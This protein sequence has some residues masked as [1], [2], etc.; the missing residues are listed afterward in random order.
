MLQSKLVRNIHLSLHRIQVRY[1]SLS[2]YQSIRPLLTKQRSWRPSPRCW[3][4]QSSIKLLSEF[5]VCPLLVF[6]TKDWPV[7]W[8]FLNLNKVS[9]FY[10]CL[11][12]FL[13]L[14][15]HYLSLLEKEES[16][17]ENVQ[18][19]GLL[20]DSACSGEGYFWTGYCCS[21]DFCLT[22]KIIR[23]MQKYS[24]VAGR[25]SPRQ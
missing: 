11:F 18:E 23:K 10:L 21:K 20:S 12:Y 5:F 17:E 7:V 9:C 22:K 3:G 8:Y 24:I 4:V 25:K 16:K 14:K 1:L 6:R 13:L 15:P 2:R 19:F